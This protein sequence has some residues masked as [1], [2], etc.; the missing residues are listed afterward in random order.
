MIMI[1]VLLFRRLCEFRFLWTRNLILFCGPQL[2]NRLQIKWSNR[3]WIANDK[4]PSP[5][6]SPRNMRSNTVKKA[7]KLPLTTK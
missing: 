2:I 7:G 3:F 5:N 6:S 4:M 1:P